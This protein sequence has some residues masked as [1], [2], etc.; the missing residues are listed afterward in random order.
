MNIL[1]ALNN[2]YDLLK[3]SNINSYKIDTEL[4]LSDSLN[5]SREKLIINF[6]NKISIGS[7]RNFLFKLNRRKKKEPVAYIIKKKE[8]W[9]NSF[10]INKDVLIPRPESEFLVEEAL[11]IINK[12]QKKLILEIGIGSGC[13]I[14]SVLKD[15]KNCSA[16]GIDSCEKAIKIAKI[17]AKL[18]H[19]KN[20]IKIL[21]TDVDN[22]SSGKYD[23]ILSNPPYIDKHQLK[24][25][26]VCEYEPHKA[27]D[28]GING[29]EILKKVILKS[30]KLLKTNG[31]L[32]V[33]I[34]SNQKYKVKSL[35]NNNNFF[36]N[37]IIKDLS[38][39]DRC[40]VSTKKL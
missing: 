20:R 36:V 12:D 34:G 29:I 39:H 9:K 7:Y 2:G 40:L 22:F 26:G 18:H 3:S 35:L 31:K 4:L 30:S 33:E 14:T 1:K 38:G 15:R 28:G 37:K 21:K 6:K 32:I 16:I 13:V 17:N 23:L 5:I 11:K 8:F 19:I 24:Y 27:L 25:L 10:Y